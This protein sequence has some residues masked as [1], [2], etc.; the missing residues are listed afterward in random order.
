MHKKARKGVGQNK[1]F[2]RCTSCV[3]AGAAPRSD[4]SHTH[5]AMAKSSKIGALRASLAA[6]TA[7]F[8]PINSL[9]LIKIS[10]KLKKHHTPSFSTAAL[11]S[12][13]VLTVFLYSR[14]DPEAHCAGF[15]AHYK[16]V[17]DDVAR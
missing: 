3:T 8:L 2:G 4:Q 11:L 12:S 17:R 6:V 14:S 7:S 13:T 16:R 10:W 1:N 9:N 15:P 5:R